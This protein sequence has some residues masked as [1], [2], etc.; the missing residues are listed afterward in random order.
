[1]GFL[2]GLKE[3]SDGRV[4]ASQLYDTLNKN[5]EISKALMDNKFSKINEK[6]TDLVFKYGA[7]KKP[8]EMLKNATGEEFNKDYYLKDLER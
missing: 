5:M 2:C 7:S 3:K 4:Y 6:L 8:N 1:M